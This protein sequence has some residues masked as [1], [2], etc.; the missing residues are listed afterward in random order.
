[1]PPELLHEVRTSGDDPC[2]RT[3]QQLVAAEGHDVRALRDGVGDVRLVGRHPVSGREQPRSDVVQERDRSRGCERRE[4]PRGRAR[5]EAHH[6]VVRGVDLQDR[7]GALGDGGP[8][9]ADPRAVGRADLDELRAARG[10]DVRDPELPADLD[11]LPARD[12]D[13]LALGERREAQ[14]ERRRAVVHHQRVLGAGER[15][16]QGLRAG[17]A[18]PAP[19][20]LPIHLE[21]RVVAGRPRRRPRRGLR[22]RRPAQARVQDHAGG[23]DDGGEP[24]GNRRRAAHRACQDLVPGGRLRPLARLGPH[25]VQGLGERLLQE[26]AAEGGRGAPPRSRAQEGV[27]RG[28]LAARVGPVSEPILRHVRSLP[29]RVAGRDARPRVG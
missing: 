7:P 11:Q 25:L 8:V 29:G 28:H 14:Q 21:V 17:A 18:L 12:Q 19:A 26:R 24:V 10:H 2:L 6:A 15:L 22:Q 9:V 1:M 20:G 27:E 4:V 23:V 5:G 13:L 3:A 16:H